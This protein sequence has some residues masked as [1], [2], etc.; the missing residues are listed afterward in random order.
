MITSIDYLGI[1]QGRP[2]VMLDGM[3]RELWHETMGF[4]DDWRTVFG[5]ELRTCNDEVAHL[6]IT[7]TGAAK[8]F[9]FKLDRF[10]GRC[11]FED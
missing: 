11:E 6:T 8:T 2:I 7:D 10:Q 9:R 4:L 3:E 5:F 1:R